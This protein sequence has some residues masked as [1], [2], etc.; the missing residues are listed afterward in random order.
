[1]EQS[2]DGG[3]TWLNIA[4]LDG[5]A[6]SFNNTGLVEGTDSQ[7]R[8]RAQDDGGFSLYT[9]SADASTLPA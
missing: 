9:D 1:V 6:T 3:N 5:N 8:V 2:L 7:Y 4:T